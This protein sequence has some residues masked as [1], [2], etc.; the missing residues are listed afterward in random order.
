MLQ[1][2]PSMGAH[3]QCVEPGS[4]NPKQLPAFDQFQDQVRGASRG[5]WSWARA[6]QRAYPRSP[7]PNIRF[8]NQELHSF[9]TFIRGP[10]QGT[11]ITPSKQCQTQRVQGRVSNQDPSSLRHSTQLDQ[12]DVETGFTMSG[13][14]Q[15]HQG[16]AIAGHLTLCDGDAA[17]KEPS[18]SRQQ[19]SANVHKL[20]FKIVCGKPGAR[21]CITSAMR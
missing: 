16:G 12:D 2:G 9:W 5:M 21:I 4:K 20:K 8:Q 6:P 19:L 18:I 17:L 11:K 13:P 1:N 7:L 14:K 3:F 10:Y 15:R